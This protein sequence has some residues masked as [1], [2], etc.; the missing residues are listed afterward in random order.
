MST[1]KVVRWVALGVLVAL[2]VLTIVAAAGSRTEPLRRLVVETLTERLDS[3]VSLEAFSVDTFPT[4]VVSGQGLLIR[5]RTQ[6]ASQPPLIS[7]ASFTVHCSIM[8]MLRRPRR[9]RTVTLEGLVVNIPPGG[10]KIRRG[11]S[12]GPAAGRPATELTPPPAP[13]AAD[14]AAAREENDG[15]SPIIVDELLANDAMLRIIPRRADKRPKEFAIRSLRMQ[16]LG[17]GQQMPFTASL[18]NPI[19]RGEI[20]T[21]GTFG[22]WRKR[23]AG[24]DAGRRRLQLPERRPWHHQG[25]RRHPELDRHV[26]RRVEPHRG[27]G[28]DRHRRLPH[29]HRRPPDAADARRSTR[30]STAPTATRI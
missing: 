22:P 29:R 6:E 15:E 24:L 4:V 26:R 23:R 18:T 16:S 17:L 9:F 21:S 8:D 13:S 12:D 28:Q 25:D 14:Q 11:G 5:H 1:V 7:I 27:Q 20:E 3:D 10:F 19:P 2:V 30:S